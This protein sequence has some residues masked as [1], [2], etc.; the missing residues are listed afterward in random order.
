MENVSEKIGFRL[1]FVRALLSNWLFPRGRGF[2]GRLLLRGFS[3]WPEKGTFNFKYGTFSDVS[4]LPWPKG[5]KQLFLYN[6]F[7]NTEI[8]M[9][10]RVLRPVDLIVDAGANY[11]YWTLIGSRLVGEE[12][13]V[14]AFEPVPSSFSKLCEHL[15]LSGADNVQA[16]NAALSDTKGA[17]EM[18]LCLDDPLA[19]N[20]SAG[21]SKTSRWGETVIC[22]KDR[23]DDAPALEGQIP[24][25]L[26]IDVEGC[27]LLVLKGSEKILR[28]SAPPVISVEWNLATAES[29]GFHPRDLLSY[30][31]KFG[32]SFYLAGNKGLVPFKEKINDY[33]WIPMVWALH[34]KD[35]CENKK[36][37]V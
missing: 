6:E 1:R 25:L 2:A 16:I 7:E 29:M 35:I 24:T 20:S 13:R 8:E 27:E 15:K 21:K 37:F 14:L 30:L 4:L 36:W 3:N 11:G 33:E 17:L 31:G 32:Y 19:C 9:W 10:K 22:E 26:K 34:E 18:N 23:L 12:G 28:S 5:F